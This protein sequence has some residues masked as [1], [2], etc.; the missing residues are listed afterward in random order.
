VTEWLDFGAINAG[1]AL[2]LLK[3][4]NIDN[5]SLNNF[6]LDRG[7]FN[8]TLIDIAVSKLKSGK[9]PGAVKLQKEH[10][11]FAHP[12]LYD[13]LSKLFYLIFASGYVPSQFG[14]GVIIPI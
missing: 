14:R 1:E 7:L 11:L 6:G 4:T 10:L 13:V 9:A 3:E 5:V 12:I 2:L 8:I